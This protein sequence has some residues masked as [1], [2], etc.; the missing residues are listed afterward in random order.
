MAHGDE[1]AVLAAAKQLARSSSDIIGPRLR[2]AILYGSLAT[3]QFVSGHS[4]ID[5]LLITDG[6]LADTE[7]DALEALVRQIDLAE[8]SGIDLHVVT[9]DVARTPTQAPIMELHVGR[10]ERSSIGVEIERRTQSPDLPT[11]LAMARADGYALIG[12]EPSNVIE[13][14][15][16]PW[17]RERGRHWLT[18]W[19]SRIDDAEEAA[20]MV[21]TACRIWR[22]GVEGV[23][24]AKTQAAEWALDRNPSLT[25]VR[26]AL[27]QYGAEPAAPLD[28]DA[29]AQVLD[30]ALRE[31]TNLP[32]N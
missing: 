21:L 32:N 16:P 31:T 30:I 6:T 2:S 9:A 22:F 12:M 4:D 27:R 25:A 28:E 13:P 10:Y 19:Q 29:I 26:Q 18:T 5:L 1:V 14:V 17:I 23:H 24:C 8:A 7:V 11:E 15:P 20:F 3:G